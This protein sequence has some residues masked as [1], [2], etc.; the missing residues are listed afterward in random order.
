MQMIYL[1]MNHLAKKWRPNSRA[2]QRDLMSHWLKYM[3]QD[4]S[5]MTI[6]LGG[7]SLHGDKTYVSRLSQQEFDLFR[8]ARPNIPWVDTRT[9][10]DKDA[11]LAA[12]RCPLHSSKPDA[13]PVWHSMSYAPVGV[14]IAFK[15]YF[16]AEV[17]WANLD[18]EHWRRVADPT[19]ERA[20]SL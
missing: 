7:A 20:L 18:Y 19:I 3:R 15:E 4:W 12:W 9:I 11:V 8:A 16:G 14:F 5:L 1:E 17:S 10:A 2:A 13:G 6:G